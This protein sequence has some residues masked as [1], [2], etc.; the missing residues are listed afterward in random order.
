METAVSAQEAQLAQLVSIVTVMSASP[1][2]LIVLSATL[3]QSARPVLLV[4]NSMKWLFK[5]LLTLTVL[6][7]AVTAR[8]SS[9]TA[10]MV[11]R[12]TVTAATLTARSRTDG[13]AKAD[14]V[15]KLVLAST[16]SPQ[17]A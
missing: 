4:S 8:D 9:L 14:Q 11:T 1:A 15:S 6:K 13:T 10:M 5:V 17:D 12:R 16:T 7:S 3:N 2:R